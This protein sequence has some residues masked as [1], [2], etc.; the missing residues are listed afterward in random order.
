MRHVIGSHLQTE[1]ITDI[2]ALDS[3]CCTYNGSYAPVATNGRTLFAPKHKNLSTNTSMIADLL[4]RGSSRYASLACLS[5][6]N[7]SLYGQTTSAVPA[8]AVILLGM[9]VDGHHSSGVPDIEAMPTS[10]RR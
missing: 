4:I 8:Y 9:D 1:L 10:K 5:E 6:I 7:E 3:A 2:V